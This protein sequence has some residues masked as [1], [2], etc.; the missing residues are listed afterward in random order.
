VRVCFRHFPVAA[1]HPRARAAACAA[2]AA[3]LQDAFWAMHDAL[4]DDPG[5]LEDPHLWARAERIGLDVARFNAD[6]RSPGIAERVRADLRGGVR[7][8]VSSTPAA[9]LDGVLHGGR[10]AFATLANLR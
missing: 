5:R 7:A 9:F 4:F 1:G 10:E 3:G 2:E 8:G 6:R